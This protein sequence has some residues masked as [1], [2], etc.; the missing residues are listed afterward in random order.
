MLGWRAA[1]IGVIYR[2]V[3]E[4]SAFGQMRWNL[5]VDDACGARAR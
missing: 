3:R 2:V 1:G 4:R 5:T